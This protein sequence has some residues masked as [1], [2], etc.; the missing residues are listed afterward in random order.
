MC[1]VTHQH[2]AK[3]RYY[4]TLET[5]CSFITSTNIM[6]TRIIHCGYLK[7]KSIYIK[8]CYSSDLVAKRGK[9]R[10]R[11]KLGE[12]IIVEKKRKEV[13]MERN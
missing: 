8:V 10:F 6:Y 3:L 12:G 4:D 5:D 11:E 13:A 2:S 9:L 7:G 1:T